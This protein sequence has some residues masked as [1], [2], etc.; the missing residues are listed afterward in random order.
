MTHRERS[1]REMVD[2]ADHLATVQAQAIAALQELAK[3]K[4]SHI[5]TLQALVAGQQEEI[6]RLTG[7][8]T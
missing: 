6:L 4:Q 3:E 2:R 5:Y 7:K 1:L 8:R